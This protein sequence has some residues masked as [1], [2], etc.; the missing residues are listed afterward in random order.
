MALP[1]SPR[2]LLVVEDDSDQRQVLQ[3]R[4]QLYGY[5]VA[6]VADGGTAM[7]TLESGSFT[8]GA[9][10]SARALSRLGLFAVRS[11]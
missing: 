11:V 2:H 6:C 1:I 8:P 9:I 10:S 4:L 3:D 5:T 7:D